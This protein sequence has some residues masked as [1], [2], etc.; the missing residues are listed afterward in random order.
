MHV[1]AYWP[2]AS[3]ALI[4]ADLR[5]LQREIEHSM[6]TR[7]LSTA[8][9]EYRNVAKRPQDLKESIEQFLECLRN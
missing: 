3:I 6:K 9:R 8:N 1:Y 2:F 5:I 4:H 7:T